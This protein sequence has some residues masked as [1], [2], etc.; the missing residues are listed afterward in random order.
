M[1]GVSFRCTPPRIAN[2]HARI[3][4]GVV[5]VMPTGIITMEIGIKPRIVPHMPIVIT[6]IKSP[7]IVIIRISPIIP[8]PERIIHSIVPIVPIA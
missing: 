7:M 8:P 2:T 4:T 6:R 3:M 1:V 5:P